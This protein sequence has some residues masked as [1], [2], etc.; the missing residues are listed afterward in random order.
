MVKR[1]VANKLFADKI[2]KKNSVLFFTV[3]LDVEGVLM[4]KRILIETK[5]QDRYKS[6]LA[7]CNEADKF[8][9]DELSEID[10]IAY[11]S[12]YAVSRKEVENIKELLTSKE[13]TMEINLF[14]ESGFDLFEEKSEEKKKEQTL[15]ERFNITNLEPYKNILISDLPFSNRVVN[16]LRR[17]ICFTLETLLNYSVSDILKLYHVGNNS[18]KN[19]IEVLENFFNSP[20]AT[21]EFF[22]SVRKESE[23]ERL[24]Q[25]LKKR[26]SIV[27]TEAFWNVLISKLPFSSSVQYALERN[28]CFTLMKLLDHSEAELSAFKHFG[29]YSN[30]IKNFSKYFVQNILEVLENF[31][32]NSSSTRGTGSSIKKENLESPRTLKAIFK[33]SEFE[34]YKN[35]FT[36]E[37][38]FN[39]RVQHLFKQNKIFTLEK[40]LNYSMPELLAMRSFGAGSVK[41]VIEVLENFFNIQC[42]VET[43]FEEDKTLVTLESENQENFDKEESTVIKVEEPK[44]ISEEDLKNFADEMIEVAIKKEIQLEVISKRANGKTL[45]EIGK[46]FNITRERV[47]QIE[48]KSIRNF[49]NC[50][51]SKLKNFF[52]SILSLLGGKSFIT[53]EDLKNFIGETSAQIL[54]FFIYKIDSDIK[55]F[56]IDEATNTIVFNT[57]S[58]K[59]IDYDKLIVNLPEILHKD[60]LQEKIERI[61]KEQNCS[62]ELLRLKISQFYKHSGQFFHKGRLTLNFQCGYVLREKF[63]SGYK[64]ADETHYNRFIRYLREFFGY[65]GEIS[66]RA[67]DAQIASY[68]GILCDR[69]KYIHPDFLHVPQNLVLLINEYIQ[70][71]ER[72]VLPY[73]EI[74]TALK[75]KFVGTQITNQHILQGV[76][77]YCG[78]PYNLSRDC[79]TKEANVNL[80]VEFN[81]FVEKN[82]EVTKQE[83]KDE[84]ISF[85]EHNIA[86]L[87]QR[88]PEVIHIGNGK[89]LHS[90][91]LNLKEN[92]SAEIEE[93]LQSICT[94]KPVTSHYLYNL[95]WERF[96]DFLYRND[97]EDSDKLFG[98]LKYMFA[99][100]FNFSR[101]Y[102]SAAN[103]AGFSNKK[104]LLQHLEDRDEVEIEDIVNLCEDQGIKYISKS[105]LV[106][107]L[108]P[109]FIRVDEFYLRRLESIGV[110]DE[111]IMSVVENVQL[112]M[113]RNGGW[114]SAKV[115][116]DF[117]WLPRLEV[118]WNSFL[119]ESIVKLSENDFKV[120]HFSSTTGESSTAIFVSDDF[121]EDDF[122]SFCLK[123]LIEEQER[124]PFQTKEE[125]LNWLIENGLA[126]RKLPKFL[127]GHL[128][129]KANYPVVEY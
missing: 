110:T 17:N 49:L 28:N 27:N 107:S 35:V 64:I 123:I 115:F 81:N 10:F 12:K 79:I 44:L 68:V 55:A 4:S 52:D 31:F 78:T 76:I 50:N 117:E 37:L 112:A 26:F 75:E 122:N 29:K 106:E 77:K 1:K 23:N 18:V 2:L 104:A 109:E 42:T 70:K 25:P 43:T 20:I 105:I 45:E 34:S 38:P 72:T 71:S 125:I 39:N 21:K 8:F 87:L 103:I 118:S 93:F 114:Q 108:S 33:I 65:E 74:F 99:D 84:F 48:K 126:N 7:Y 41:N 14:D 92:D 60:E 91:Q 46:S 69:G 36:N 82:G 120:L 86:M 51:S 62:E 58:E 116:P 56:Y 59:P 119:L 113:E 100:K 53:F 32:N 11:R 90:T 88:C 57:T 129:F 24:T 85:Q 61:A 66:Q 98:I 96:Q 5:L 67:L 80:T 83:I 128:N 124:T 73:K 89:Y 3:F 54:W 16:Q 101:P 97:I 63:Q 22:S 47:R 6:F 40:L 102:I 9:I 121:E 111:V 127:E 19:I 15:K 94:D 13:P 30:K 95:F